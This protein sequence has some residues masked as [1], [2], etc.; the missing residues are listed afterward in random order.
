MS[1]SIVV[2]GNT[3][4]LDRLDGYLT[5]FDKHA[6]SIFHETATEVFEEIRTQM[7]DALR[8]YPPVPAGSR[9]VRTFKLRR[10]WDVDLD[11]AGSSVYVV[12]RNATPYTRWVVGTL[13]SIDA[14]ARHTQAAFHRRNGWVVALD[15]T[16]FWF[17]VFKDA[18]I[19]AFV[20]AI[21][22]DIKG[23]K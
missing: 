10:G 18:F 16:R 19:E 13:S 1:I 22:A 5:N 7:L 11:I 14:V 2:D 17:D 8:L 23:G 20:K 12:V 6:Q 4:P 9:Y 21:I 15:T 3:A